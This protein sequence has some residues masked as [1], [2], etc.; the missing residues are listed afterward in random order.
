[1]DTSSSDVLNTWGIQVNNTG[2]THSAHGS[3]IL[4]EE[5]KTRNVST[6]R[7]PFQQM[8]D[9]NEIKKKTVERREVYY[10]QEVQA[11]LFERWCVRLEGGEG[12]SHVK[13]G[14]KA[15]QPVGRTWVK[16]SRQ[17]WAQP[18]LGTAG[19]PLFSTVPGVKGGKRRLVGD[20]LIEILPSLSVCLLSVLSQKF[21]MFPKTMDL[22]VVSATLSTVPG[23]Y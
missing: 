4:V 12:G 15:W 20:G 8:G 6:W 16:V 13:S 18:I 7:T 23:S 5:L 19:R 22:C 17:V 2:K 14:Y 10:T 1:M 11:S 3:C 21:G 9:T